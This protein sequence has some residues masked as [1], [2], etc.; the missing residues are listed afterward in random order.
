MRT[1]LFFGSFN[2]PHKG[3][4]AIAEYMLRNEDLNEIWFVISPQ[5]PLKDPRILAPETD[6]LVMVERA[7]EGHKSLKTCDI[8]FSLPRPS[9][10]INT[11]NT[12]N[13]LYPERKWIILMGSDGLQYFGQ[14]KDYQ[15]ITAK[16]PRLVYPRPGN[17]Y[18]HLPNMENARLINAPIF[19]ISSTQLRSLILNKENE[20]VLEY[21]DRNVLEYIQ[22]HNLYGA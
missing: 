12:L 3:H 1:G 5:N 4:V 15:K 17:D 14:W 11:I 7:I 8:E 19:E 2:P 13:N 18:S 20:K 6:R 21:I 10:T 16:Y 9:Y 22:L